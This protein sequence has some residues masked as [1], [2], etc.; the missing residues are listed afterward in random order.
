M[1]R[2]AKLYTAILYGFY[3]D[4]GAI[5]VYNH[6]HAHVSLNPAISPVHF[7]EFA[8]ILLVSPYTIIVVMH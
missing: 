2:N 4:T 8:R 1:G 3:V 6:A 7:V 5:H